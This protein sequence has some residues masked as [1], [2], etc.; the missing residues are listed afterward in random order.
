MYLEHK[1]VFIAGATGMVGSN[2]IQY[3]LEHYPKVTIRASYHKTTPSIRHSRLEYV[4]GDLLSLDDCKAMVG[5]C[6]CAI[7]A[8]A[9]TAN[10]NTIDAFPLP[11]VNENLIMNVR[12][13][14]AFQALGVERAIYIGSATLY[15]DVEGA[16]KEEGLDF[17]R[18]PHPSYFGFG[19]LSRY[20]EKLYTF[21]HQQSGRDVL[22]VR[23]ANIFGPFAKFD[24]LTSNFIPAI[25]R[26]AVDK[27]DP[28]EVWG[29]PDVTRDVLYAGDFA[30][31]ITMMLDDDSIKF[32]IFNIGSGVR[33]TVG[34]VV[35]LALKYAGHNPKEIRYA[36]D[37]PSTVRSRVLDCT[38]VKEALGWQAQ[39]TVEQ[40]VEK[41]LKWWMENKERWKR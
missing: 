34:D 9:K 33:T 28:F 12:M 4:Q 18:D 40:G 31:A 26:K 13:L 38:K 35:S 1:K 2:I 24:P 36:I 25:I 32:D 20:V 10:A 27:I 22:I 39:Y 19:W 6:H 29:S 41:T 15:Q 7:M 37:K 17:S 21:W 5:D 3:M 11:F 30:R 16:I 14:E 8:A 23:A